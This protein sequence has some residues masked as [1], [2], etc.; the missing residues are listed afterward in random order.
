MPSAAD[1]VDRILLSTTPVKEAASQQR[2]KVKV[3]AAD[4]L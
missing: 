4:A 2:V 3:V 1:K